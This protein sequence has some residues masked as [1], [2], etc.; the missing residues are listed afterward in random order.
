MTY[1]FANLDPQ[2]VTSG[3]LDPV[4]AMAPIDQVSIAYPDVVSIASWKNVAWTET[5][6]GF[7][8]PLPISLLCLWGA[9]LAYR[10]PGAAGVFAVIGLAFGAL[11]AYM[12]RR[13]LVIGR[14]HVRI[15]GRYG[16]VSVQH[17]K[18]PAFYLE[19]FRRCGLVVPP[20]P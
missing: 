9:A 10:A 20:I 8:V 17:D 4:V 7:L 14:R 1:R 5:I 13:G 12:I 2:G 15:V 19:L 3:T 11:A 16:E 18:S 6:T